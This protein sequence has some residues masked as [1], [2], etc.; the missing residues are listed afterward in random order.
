MWV[1]RAYMVG[2]EVLVVRQHSA[3]PPRA[4]QLPSTYEWDGRVCMGWA[5]VNGM[6]GCEKG[7]G[8]WK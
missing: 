3:K 2:L 1:R 4:M 7:I 5:G 8:R 6:G